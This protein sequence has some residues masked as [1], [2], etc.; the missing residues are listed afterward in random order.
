M[1]EIDLSL[2]VSLI[3]A[4]PGTLMLFLALERED[5]GDTFL[6]EFNLTFS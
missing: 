2:S 3:E 5:C 6:G 4:I 1:T